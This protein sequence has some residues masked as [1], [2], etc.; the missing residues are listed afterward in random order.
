VFEV[1]RLA[2][3]ALELLNFLDSMERSREVAPL[4]RSQ[5]PLASPREPREQPR[6]ALPRWQ[7]RLALALPASRRLPPAGSQT[8]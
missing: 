7:D 1:I 5:E 6:A 4:L 2:G 8:H 3:P